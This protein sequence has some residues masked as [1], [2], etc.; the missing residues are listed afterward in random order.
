MKNTNFTLQERNQPVSPQQK[1]E[2][3]RGG[4]F[5]LICIHKYF[6]IVGGHKQC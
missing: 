2:L 3:N 4:N 1:N 6:M 5:L